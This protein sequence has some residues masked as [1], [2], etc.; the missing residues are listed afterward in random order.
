MANIIVIYASMTGNTEE[1]AEEIAK[2]IREQACDVEVKSVLDASAADL[3]GY[4]GILL[5]AYTWG[6]GELPDEFL[7]FYDDMD[8]IALPGKQAAVFGSCDS[9]YPGFGAAVDILTDKLK[10]MGASVTMPGLKIELSPSA[11]EKLE[12]QEFGKRFANQVVSNYV[13][14]KESLP[15]GYG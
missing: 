2:G 13:G 1:I 9:G 15:Y 4:D 11:Q 6:N 10:A 5:G 12:C 8:S 7:D 3:Q 14:R